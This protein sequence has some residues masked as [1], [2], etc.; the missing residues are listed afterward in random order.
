[1]AKRACANELHK[2]ENSLSKIPRESVAHLDFVTA[3]EHARAVLH[4]KGRVTYSVL[5]RQFA[6]DEKEPHE[7]VER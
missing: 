6:L 1:M 5:K 4:S 3:I 2:D 7:G